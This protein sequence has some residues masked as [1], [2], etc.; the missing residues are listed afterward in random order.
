MQIM[1]TYIIILLLRHT[2]DVGEYCASVFR[3]RSVL[4]C[5]SPVSNQSLNKIVK[6]K[7]RK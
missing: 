6:P 2:P 1:C 3:F 4:Q 7:V 5:S